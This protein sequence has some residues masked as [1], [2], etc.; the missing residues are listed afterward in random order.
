MIQ[1]TRLILRSAAWLRRRPILI[2]A[3]LY[4]LLSFVFTFPL[5]LRL[6]TSTYGYSGDNLGAIHYFS[7]WKQSLLS[8]LDPRDS[9]LEETPF[10][11]T[12]DNESGAILYYLPVKLLTLLTDAVAGYNLVLLL[13]FP[14]AALA[15]FWLAY[16][17]TGNRFA[18]FIAGL[19]YGFSP[20]HAW[21]A[22]NH[23]DLA[24]IWP[25]PLYVLALWNLVKEP[26]TKKGIFVKGGLAGVT[27]AACVLTNFYYGYFMLLLTGVF[28]LAFWL[29]GVW[30]QRRK[31][32]NYIIP[33]LAA[34]FV[35]GFLAVILSMPFMYKTLL[36]SRNPAS[37]GESTLKQDAFHRPFDNLISLS[38]RPWDYLIPSQ[39]HPIWGKYV[40]ALYD[41]IR[42]KSNDFKTISAVPHERTI[43]LGWVS[44][45]FSLLSLWLWRRNSSFREKYG[46]AVFVF[47]A[48]AL[49]LVL[50]SMP[51]FIII[52]NIQ[53][54]LPSFYLYKLFP[55]F[56]SYVRLGVVVLIGATVLAAM[57]I[58]FCL[59]QFTKFPRYQI[60]RRSSLYL[61]PAVL[62]I[63]VL[64]DFANIPPAKVID[65]L[66]TPPAYLWL[67]A[68]PGQSTILEWPPSFNVT[69]GLFYQRIHGKGL[70]NWNSQS[71]YYR[72]WQSLPSLY[73]PET[74]GKLS[75]LGIRY[76]LVHK[77][78][79]F[80]GENPADDL[81][82]TRAVKDPEN[83][84]SVPPGMK[85]AFESPAITVF[86]LLKENQAKLVFITPSK[87]GYLLRQ[88][89]EGV[90]IISGATGH[91]YIYNFSSLETK[92]LKVSLSWEL[93]EEIKSQ[94]MT[95]DYNG[96]ELP[97]DNNYVLDIK[98]GQNEL[99]VERNSP[100]GQC[101]PLI[102][103]NIK[104]QV[105]K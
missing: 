17:I 9:F 35:A 69:E 74:A 77:T 42:T 62:A 103:S 97:L 44:L 13:S 29:H 88:T 48:T 56:R 20:Y 80:P 96:E 100:C 71:P 5:I 98:P 47:G 78:L 4:L 94:V 87:S 15:M 101:L 76:V 91:F 39:D 21:K 51:P 14:A 38:A 89:S 57:A 63:L 59:G 86:E 102:I 67:A 36:E 73:A 31:Y 95:L 90:W 28:L 23:L 41:W 65:F 58:D 72:F 33:Q 45:I 30:C 61:V 19:I 64:L 75:V 79:L 2:A 99:H 34:L 83:Y 50:I 68:Q 49:V 10:G 16:R 37:S 25:L 3:L 104:L 55:M 32:L 81:W 11:V 40:P 105:I 92:L 43:Y 6:G 66:P 60:I 52:K 18:G 70:A 24:L 27:L 93:P 54:N 22:Y 12:L 85:L 46:Q 1:P 7:W 26:L 84:R 8:G 53:L 82:Y